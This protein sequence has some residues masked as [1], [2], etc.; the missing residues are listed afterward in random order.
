MSTGQGGCS[1]IS[2][3]TFEWNLSILCS[4]P[5]HFLIAEEYLSYP[6]TQLNWDLPDGN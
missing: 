4:I 1:Y 6:M 3:T 2:C 5:N